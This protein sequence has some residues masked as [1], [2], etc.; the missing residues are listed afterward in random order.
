MNER[1]LSDS[2]NRSDASRT[3]VCKLGGMRA[4]FRHTRSDIKG[5]GPPMIGPES[6]AALFADVS[7]VKLV[8]GS[9]QERARSGRQDRVKV[10]S[11]R[12]NPILQP[13]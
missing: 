9:E 1:W 3:I 2:G 13:F 12:L 7:T 10:I 4:D 6:R 5:D 8:K 11:R